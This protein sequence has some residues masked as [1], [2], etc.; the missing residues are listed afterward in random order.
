MAG[1]KSNLSRLSGGAENGSLP[2]WS[3][4]CRLIYNE[5][6]QRKLW[7]LMSPGGP[8]R[9]SRRSSEVMRYYIFPKL[10]RLLA[11]QYHL[12][13]Y[14]AVIVLD[15]SHT[16]FPVSYEPLRLEKNYSPL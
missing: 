1:E 12:Q 15:T 10:L 6:R 2:R 7:S 9:S 4:R 16:R 13:H 5:E 3:V 8:L 11:P 14:A